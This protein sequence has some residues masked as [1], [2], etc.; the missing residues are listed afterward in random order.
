MLWDMG[1]R[2]LSCQEKYQSGT[3]LWRQK[4]E[5][6]FKLERN[7]SRKYIVDILSGSVPR[8]TPSTAKQN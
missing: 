3:A 1:N 7:V 8:D 2:Y 6:I 4:I 5:A